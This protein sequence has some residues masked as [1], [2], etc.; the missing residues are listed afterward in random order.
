M[1]TT[2]LRMS[3]LQKLARELPEELYEEVSDENP[4]PSTD[5][6][7][8]ELYRMYRQEILRMMPKMIK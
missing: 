5:E 3:N 4:I 8:K 2:T 1:K 6:F 7:K